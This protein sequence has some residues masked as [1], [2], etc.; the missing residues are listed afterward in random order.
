MEFPKGEIRVSSNHWKHIISCF[1]LAVALPLAAQQKGQYV[2]GQ[3]GLNAGVMPDPGI[4]YANLDL[5]YST[6]TLTDSRG[7]ALNPKASL[8]LWI[9]EN[10]FYYV[11]DNK[12]LGGNFGVM[13]MA[14]SVANGSLTLDQVNGSGSAYGLT[15][16]WLQPFNLGWHLKRAD[17]QVGDALVYP[18]GRYSPGASEKTIKQISPLWTEPA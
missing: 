15:D 18:T 6:D 4:T 12:I 14:P 5:N 10:I 8:S 2:P 17:I 13:I 7:N 1:V 16:I 9:V 3:F 11:A